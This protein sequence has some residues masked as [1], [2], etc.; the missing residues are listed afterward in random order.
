MPT[1][2]VGLLIFVVLLAPGLAF[3][4]QR[5][6]HFVP[7]TASAFRET[8]VVI[9]AS[10]IANSITLCIFSL[11][12]FIWPGLTPD[13]GQLLASPDKYFSANYALVS[14]WTAILLAIAT[15]LGAL[16]ALPPG[17]VLSAWR[18]LPSALQP[19]WLEDIGNPI[20]YKSAWSRLMHLRPEDYDGPIDVWVSCEL[21]DGTYLAGPLFSL[22]PDVDEDA[23]RELIIMAPVSYRSPTSTSTEE[24]EVGA[25]TVS[26]RNLKYVAWSYV[27][28]DVA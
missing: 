17:P 4:V 18:K 6:T 2:L 20:V 14:G 13:P 11:V 10:V 27:R 8:A 16:A 23:D 28:R 9:L 12:R 1:S 19:Q 15:L 3:V 5:E 21:Q 22:N 25:V 24:L 7:R 26:A